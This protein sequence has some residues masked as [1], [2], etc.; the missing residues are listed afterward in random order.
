[1]KIEIKSVAEKVLFEY[2]CVDNTIRKT[3]EEAVKRDT[4]LRG[5]YLGGADL[6]GADLGGA[7]LGDAD[8]G[9]AYLGGADLGGADLGGAYLGGAYLGGADLGDWGKLQSVSDILTIGAIGSRDGYTT[10][11]HTNKGIFVRCGCFKG[12][13]EEFGRKVKE[14]H[15]GNK[16]ERDYMAMIEFAKIKFEIK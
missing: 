6:G 7:D 12:T 5:A 8:L 15:K 10:I 16:H 1:M 13:L 4:Y 14:T 9:G 3:L 2:D 11:F